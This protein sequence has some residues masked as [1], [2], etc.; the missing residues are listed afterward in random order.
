MKVKIVVYTLLLTLL[1][2]TISAYFFD[3]SIVMGTPYSCVSFVGLEYGCIDFA[4]LKDFDREWQLEPSLRLY[5]SVERQLF[6][7]TAKGNTLGSRPGP[8]LVIHLLWIWGAVCTLVIIRA[9]YRA[10]ISMRKNDS[11]LGRQ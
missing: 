11:K 10:F 6:F 9:A 4:L 1:L 7:I 5:E 3:L 8:Q 2:L